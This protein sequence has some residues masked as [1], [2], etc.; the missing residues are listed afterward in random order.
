MSNKVATTPTVSPFPPS[1]LP[2][3][4]SLL[5]AAQ[6]LW[7]V[8]W[9]AAY[10]IEDGLKA[11]E[12]QQQ[13]SAK[14]LLAFSFSQLYANTNISRVGTPPRKGHLRPRTLTDTHTHTHT[15]LPAAHIVNV[16]RQS[17]CK[18]KR[19]NRETTRSEN[20]TIALEN[21]LQ[22]PRAWERHG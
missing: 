1:S 20:T 7:C 2:S 9:A 12:K 11:S 18:E 10:F 5:P 17:H 14:N 19:K 6:G 4:L 22:L 8:T 21:A 13:L 16:N 3:T 15:H